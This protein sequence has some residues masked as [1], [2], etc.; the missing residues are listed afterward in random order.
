MSKVCVYKNKDSK[1]IDVSEVPSYYEKGWTDE[2]GKKEMSALEID[3]ACGRAK[4]RTDP[5]PT[6]GHMEEL[7]PPEEIEEVEVNEDEPVEEGEE[8]TEEEAVEPDGLEELTKKKLIERLEGLG[9]SPDQ[10]ATKKN[11]IK[12]IR[13]IEAD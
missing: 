8:P 2:P 12:A 3:I 5:C 4:K 11:L 10:N 9:Q 1:I 6:C 13:F 7:P